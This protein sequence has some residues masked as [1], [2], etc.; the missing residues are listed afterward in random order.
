MEEQRE[1]SISLVRCAFCSIRSTSNSLKVV[2][3]DWKDNEKLIIPGF[4][5]RSDLSLNNGFLAVTVTVVENIPEACSFTS[6]QRK[7]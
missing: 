2:I 7:T 1:T 6:V 5:Y 3:F 4:G